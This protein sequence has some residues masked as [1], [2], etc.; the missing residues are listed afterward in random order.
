MLLIEL[1][2]RARALKAAQDI[3]AQAETEMLQAA[4]SA[5]IGAFEKAEAAHRKAVLQVEYAQDAV[6]TA[7][8]RA[9]ATY[10]AEALREALAD[11]RELD[12]SGSEAALREVE[13]VQAKTRKL[14]RHGRA[15]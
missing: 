13:R 9:L 5:S 3:E 8:M 12:E 11:T 4:G 14:G 7:V 1:L 15:D 6:L 10:E 2:K